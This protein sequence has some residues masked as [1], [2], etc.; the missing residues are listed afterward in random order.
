[1][2]NESKFTGGVLGHIGWNILAVLIIFF[3]L[4]IATPWALCLIWKW[5]ITNTIIDGRKLGFK[6]DGLSLL[7]NWIKWWFFCIITLGIYGLWVP[8]K[9]EQ[10]KVKNTYF[11]N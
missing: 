1:M 6:G 11:V 4:G 8:I 9:L 2:E 7:G 5:Q 10:W 3:T